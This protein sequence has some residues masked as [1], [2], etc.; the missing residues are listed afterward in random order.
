MK[1]QTTD[2]F[3]L[4]CR[5]LSSLRRCL[6]SVSDVILLTED[7]EKAYTNTHV[8][9][10]GKSNDSDKNMH[11][12]IWSLEKTDPGFDYPSISRVIDSV[13][14]NGCIIK[15]PEDAYTYLRPLHTS[16]YDYGKSYVAFDSQG[17]IGVKHTVAFDLSPKVTIRYN[18]VDFSDI[19]FSVSFDVDYLN[20]LKPT[21]IRI[22]VDSGDICLFEGCM[23]PGAKD[24]KYVFVMPKVLSDVR[25]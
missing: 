21:S 7:N 16:P 12:D 18:D 19:P 8:L 10:T 6:A 23:N 25:R 3:I 22:G 14:K 24:L 5:S 2:E 11:M 4:L 13:P 9:L 15:V 1:N 20:I 17:V